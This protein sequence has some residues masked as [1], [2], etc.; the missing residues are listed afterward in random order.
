VKTNGDY[1]LS[2]IVQGAVAKAVA[3][4]SLEAQHVESYIGKFFAGYQFYI[5]LFNLFI[6][7]LAVSH[8]VKY[9]RVGAAFFI[10][11]FVALGDAVLMVVFP[12]LAALRIGKTAESA[13]DYSLDNTLRGMLWLP[14]SRRAK[15]LAK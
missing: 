15:Y 8:L 4:G 12:V 10:L 3:A 2:R 5:D 6:K 11:P 9:L 14:T 1:L 13:I 7:A